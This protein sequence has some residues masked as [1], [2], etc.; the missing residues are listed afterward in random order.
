MLVAPDARASAHARTAMSRRTHLT[1]LEG[2]THNLHDAFAWLSP[3]AAR[4]DAPE[5]PQ[6]PADAREE[7]GYARDGGALTSRRRPRALSGASL[8]ENARSQ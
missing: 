3:V 8:A 2:L 1:T 7:L 5:W 6:T 4:D